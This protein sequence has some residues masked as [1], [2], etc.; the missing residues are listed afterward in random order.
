M[1]AKE[2]RETQKGKQLSVGTAR[3]MKISLTIDGINASARESKRG[4]IR[5][6]SGTFRIGD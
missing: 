2:I 5:R 3:L 6:E 4:S 1:A